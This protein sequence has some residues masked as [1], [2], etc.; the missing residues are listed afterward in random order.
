MCVCVCVYMCGY[1]CMYIHTHIGLLSGTSGEEPACQCR[2]YKR[3]EFDPW[4][5]RSPGG[6]NDNPLQDSSQ[7]NPMDRGDLWAP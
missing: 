5:T 4:A 3:P 2:S 1:V 7:E 6:G